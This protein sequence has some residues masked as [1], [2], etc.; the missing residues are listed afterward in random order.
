MD[1]PCV[2]RLKIPDCPSSEYLHQKS[3]NGELTVDFLSRRA[4]EGAIAYQYKAN[5]HAN[6]EKIYH[7]LYENTDIRCE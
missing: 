5:S 3:I 4:L 2:E 1:S 6:Y 7:L